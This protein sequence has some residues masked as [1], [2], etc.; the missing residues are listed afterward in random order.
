MAT[1]EVPIRTKLLFG[2]GDAAI[3]IKNTA[4]NLFLLFFYADVLGAPPHWIGIAIFVGKLWDAVIDPLMGYISD[5]TRSSWGRRRP[6]LLVSAIPMA[7]CFYLLF[8]PPVLSPGGTVVYLAVMGIVLFTFFSIFSTP[9]LAWGAELAR[10]YHERTE[11]VQIR[12]LMGVIG[13]AIGAVVPV[14]IVKQFPNPRMGY[15]FVAMILASL[16]AVGGMTTAIGVTDPPSRQ[17]VS[18]GFHH[19]VGGLRQTFTNR[20]FG[21]VFGTFCLMTMSAAMG[22]AVQLLVIKYRLGLYESF[23]M[24][25]AVFALS[26][27]GSFP[28]WQGLS[29]R[30]GKHRALLCGLLLGCIAPFGWII[31]QPGNLPMMLAFMV[32]GGMLTGSITLAASAAADIVE[33]DELHTGEKRAGA[34]FGIWTLGL[35]SASAFGT[36]LGGFLLTAV[37]YAADQTQSE[38]TMWWLVLIVGPL[39]ALVHAI[40][41]LVFRNIKLEATD[42][43]RIQAELDARR[44][45]LVETPS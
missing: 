19:F 10:D 33:M 40:G 43:K 5:N 15:A 27:A 35:K 23:P 31:V 24:I 8:S 45:A 22:Q 34:Y 6:Y 41:F 26:F 3:S 29:R 11:V 21:I 2:V 32:V 39:Q 42:I 4:T 7:I 9:Y 30:L 44:A 37:G 20:Q 17:R 38:Q 36:L 13:G 12:S 16:I 18:T 28:L 25:A 14:E 1:R